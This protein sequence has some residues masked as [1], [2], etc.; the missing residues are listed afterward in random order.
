MISAGEEIIGVQEAR[1][2][3]SASSL[4]GESFPNEEL[5]TRVTVP[6][7]AV[8]TQPAVSS[9]SKNQFQPFSGN[10][11]SSCIMESTSARTN[12]THRY[13][14]SHVSCPPGS[15]NKTKRPEATSSSASSNKPLLTSAEN[16][17][18]YVASFCGAGTSSKI[19]SDR[20]VNVR[21]KSI[22]R[23]NS[24]ISTI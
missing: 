5:A 3:I 1:I 16:A 19:I 20:G 4:R 14:P 7:G 24:L 12:V 17:K 8:S 9:A 2:S 18:E 22:I 10:I 23:L 11:G 13:S 15:C 6:L 21:T